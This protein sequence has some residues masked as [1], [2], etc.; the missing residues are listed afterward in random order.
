MSNILVESKPRIRVIKPDNNTTFQNIDEVRN[1]ILLGDIRESAKRLPKNSINCIV[2]SPPYFNKRIYSKKVLIDGIYHAYPEPTIWGGDANC[3]H[4]WEEHTKKVHNGRGDAQKS[5]K[6][7]EQKAV[8]DVVYH[9][10]VCTECDAYK[11]ELGQQKDPYVF[12][13]DLADCFDTLYEVLTDDG[14]LWINLGDSQWKKQ[15][16]N[17]PTLFAEEMK[18]RGWI[19]RRDIIWQK[20]NGMSASDPSNFTIDY[21]HFLFFVKNEKY[22]YETQ[23]K[24]YA[25]STLKEIMKDNPN[26]DNGKYAGTEIDGGMPLK[27]RVLTKIRFGG[28]RASEYG[29]PMYSGNAWE[30]LPGGA[31]MRSVWSF[32][33]RGTSHKHFAAWPAELAEIPI[34]FGCPTHICANCNTPRKFVYRERKIPTRPGKKVLQEKSGTVD[35]PNAGFHQSEWSTK[36]L[37]VIRTPDGFHQCSCEPKVWKK[38]I[39]LD[40]FGGTGVTGIVAKELGCDFILFDIDPVNADITL[41]R[42]KE[43]EDKPILKSKKVIQTKKIKKED[44]GLEQF[45]S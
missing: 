41:E 45:F 12:I 31:F 30:P 17:I 8:P 6:F 2:T 36:R 23:F 4:R 14:Q 18:K 10:H 29:N 11:G 34:K 37:K 42:F 19:L 9:F 40:P 27:H 13:K 16:C 26:P 43:H 35:D 21:E 22:Y 32:T 1:S 38:G 25:E 24:P 3:N 5:G 33:T 28:N 15:Q 7:S 20:P 44:K 39:V